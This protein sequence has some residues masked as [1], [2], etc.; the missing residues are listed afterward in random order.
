[1]KYYNRRGMVCHEQLHVLLRCMCAARWGPAEMICSQ[2]I[3]KNFQKLERNINNVILSTGASRWL[4]L[5]RVPLVPP[6]YPTKPLADK[7]AHLHRRYSKWL[8]THPFN[9]AS[10]MGREQ[11]H[12]SPRCSWKETASLH[13]RVRSPKLLW[14]QMRSNESHT[15]ASWCTKGSIW[16]S[17][18]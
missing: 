2:Y 1:M 13:D 15:A 14:S 4:L 10:F 12:K 11:K 6:H 5:S 17:F 16:L 3:V 8:C 7:K 18:W 9:H